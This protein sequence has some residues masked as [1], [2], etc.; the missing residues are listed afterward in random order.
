MENGLLMIYTHHV[1]TPSYVAL[2]LA[3]RALGR[4]WRVSIIHFTRDF[5]CL[6]EVAKSSSL[7]SSLE[8]R[9]LGPAV[10]SVGRSA[11]NDEATQV[12]EAWHCARRAIESRSFRLVVLDE[13][14]DPLSRG[15]LDLDQ[16]VQ[17]FNDRPRDV[18]I[19]ITG[20]NLPD[21]LLE[22]ADLVTNMVDVTP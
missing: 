6:C 20:P 13:L 1:T 21:S 22:A 12:A 16:V 18:T 2:G 10:N 8:C 17:F 9:T 4:G 11:A 19:L 15:L 3:L 7:E 5:E 14:M